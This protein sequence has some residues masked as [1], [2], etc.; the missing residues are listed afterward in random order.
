MIKRILLA[1]VFS[2]AYFGLYAYDFSAVAPTGQTLYY[3]IDNG[4]ACVTYPNFGSSY[5]HHW[6]G[7]VMPTGSLTI[8]DSV[9][10]NNQNYVVT[11]I[12]DYAFSLCIGLTSITIPNT[13]TSIGYSA[14]EGCSG[15]T[16][17]NTYW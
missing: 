6:N 17:P 8:P 16:T 4:T 14:F 1:I 3:N 11:T 15:I 12:G 5:Y 13:V 2:I 7:Y 9:F 10:Y